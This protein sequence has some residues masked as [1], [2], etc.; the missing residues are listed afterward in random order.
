[1]RK[2][3]LAA[4][5]AAAAFASHAA[6]LAVMPVSVALNTKQDRQSVT[7]QNQGR[8]RVMLQVEAVSWTQQDGTDWHAPTG[9]LVVNPPVFTVEPG[10]TQLVRVGLR[11][12]PDAQQETA[13]RLVVRQVPLPDEGADGDPGHVRV[14]L[15]LR[16][17]VYVAPAHPQR[18]QLWRA[19]KT[20]EGLV[21]VEMQNTGT[22]HQTIHSLDVAG[23]TLPRGA[24]RG[25][26][27]V[28]AGQTRRWEFRPSDAAT[29][30]VV[31]EAA[32]DAGPQRVALTL[33]PR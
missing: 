17:P 32:T 10:Q 6:D 1:M 20:P 30:Q 14:L 13:Y 8:E 33:P 9:D 31:L 16:L 15:Q 21:A 27:A 12:R 5:L 23:A 22:V 28:L 3:F 4:A 2:T 19:W 7:F 11:N 24:A 29:D 26:A 18:A 25:G